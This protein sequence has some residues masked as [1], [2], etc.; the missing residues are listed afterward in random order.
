MRTQFKIILLT[1]ESSSKSEI[2]NICKL[3]SIGLSTLHLRKPGF[4]E[5]QLRHYL[6]QI[7][8]KYHNRIVLHTHYALVKEF[9]LKGAHLTEKER[10]SK[11]TIAFLQRTKIRIVSTSFHSTVH[12]N[13]N[14]RKYEYVFLSPIFD[15]ISKKGHKS[16]F[17]LERI[18]SILKRNKIIALGG[19]NDKN[20]L[21]TKEIGFAGA[22]TIG[23]IWEGKN[24]VQQYKKLISKIK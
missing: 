9:N 14:R 3:F 22:A 18:Q 8:K 19:I 4:S 17:I 6:L 2:K 1:P 5:I 12:I 20:I 7:P 15:S 13:R 21:S 23:Y 24:P 11:K 10:A 16:R